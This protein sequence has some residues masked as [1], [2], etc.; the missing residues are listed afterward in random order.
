MNIFRDIWFNTGNCIDNFLQEKNQRPFL[1]ELIWIQGAQ[2]G[3]LVFLGTSSELKYLWLVVASVLFV[4]IYRYFLPWVL[5]HTG[6][7]MKGQGTLP[8]LQL[9]VSFST[10]PATVSL[11]FALVALVIP[12]ERRHTF[13]VVE[14]IVWLFTWRIL[15]IGVAKVQKISY[16][17]ALM[18][19]VIAPLIILI[20]YLMLRRG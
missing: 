3:L 16:E 13:E 15:L 19:I 7:L 4:L 10:V 5:F 9:A 12:G 14:W 20:V 6:K 8:Q 2:T 1:K 17:F 11:L 18:N